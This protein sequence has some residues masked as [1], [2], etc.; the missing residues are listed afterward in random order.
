MQNKN[1]RVAIDER[2]RHISAVSA[3]ELGNLLLPYIREIPACTIQTKVHL[4][5]I[6]FDTGLRRDSLTIAT[7]LPLLKSFTL[8]GAC[9]YSSLTIVARNKSSNITGIFWLDIAALFIVPVDRKSLSG[10]LLLY[11]GPDRIFLY[12]ASNKQ[13]CTISYSLVGFAFGIK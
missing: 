8:V 5:P 11:F 13:P 12:F 2:H 3:I 6:N 9:P 4:R 10:Y 1:D 7:Q